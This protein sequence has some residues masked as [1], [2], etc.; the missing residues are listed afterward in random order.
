[1]ESF[2]SLEGE[3]AEEQVIWALGHQAKPSSSSMESGSDPCHNGRLRGDL[4]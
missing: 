4:K 1:M 2:I 3:F